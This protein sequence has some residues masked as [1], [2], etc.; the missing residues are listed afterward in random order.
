MSRVSVLLLLAGMI[1]FPSLSGVVPALAQGPVVLVT[2]EYPPYVLGKGERPGL[3]TEIVTAAFAEAGVETKILYRPWRR[4]ALMIN[5]GE[6]FGAYPYARTEQRAAYAWFSE[7]IWVCRN[8]FFYLKG[9]MGDFD[10]TSLNALKEYTIAGT[11]GHYYEEIFKQKGLN[12]DYAPGEA[13]GVRKLWE[14][15]SALFAEDELVGWTLI[16]RI[17]PS[18]AHLFRSTP[19]PWNLNPQH[20]MVSRNYPGSREL[21]QRFNKGMED[22]RRNGTYD[23][24]VDRYCQRGRELPN[25]AV[26]TVR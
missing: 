24:L 23:R 8:V 4:C 15:R 21:L 2:D 16:N 18:R 22:I 1:L 12:V 14:L 6:A 20:I 19:T 7:P 17:F 13:S 10:Y 11:S 25:G 26:K 3:L 9:R 5:E